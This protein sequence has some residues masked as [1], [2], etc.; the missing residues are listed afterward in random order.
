[1]S[2]GDDVPGA[3]NLSKDGDHDSNTSE[4]D[5]KGDLNAYQPRT[6]GRARQ[7]MISG[8]AL[9][10]QDFENKEPAGEG[11]LLRS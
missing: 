5:V 11:M 1:M 9:M 4:R 7:G 3:D 8:K 2:K 6:I 10:M